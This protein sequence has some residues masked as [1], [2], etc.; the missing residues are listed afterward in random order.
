M[1]KLNTHLLHHRPGENVGVQVAGKNFWVTTVVSPIL[2]LPS[3]EP[4]DLSGIAFPGEKQER[5]TWAK[6]TTRGIHVLK[7]VADVTSAAASC[8]VM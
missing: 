6:N 4:L 2:T 8:A 3:A 5:P 1:H 7:G